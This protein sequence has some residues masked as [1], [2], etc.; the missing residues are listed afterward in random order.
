VRPPL[1]F[2]YLAQERPTWSPQDTGT[3]EQQPGTGSFLFPSVPRA[4][5]VPQL[6]NTQILPRETW[7][8][9]SADTQAYRR[10]KPHSKTARAVN[11]TDNQMVRGKGKNISNKSQGY[12]AS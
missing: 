2:K 11:T 5:P 8:P 10:N 12:L 9:R 3:K 1:L 4:D 6:S 7:S